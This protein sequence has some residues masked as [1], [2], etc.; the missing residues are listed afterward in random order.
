MSDVRR[1]APPR[2]GGDASR[3]VGSLSFEDAL[4]ELEQIVRGLEGGQHEAR[5]R[6]RLL[7]ARH[8]AAAALRGEAGRG[9]G[10][11]SPAIVARTDGSLSLRPRPAE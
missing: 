1:Q 4:A 3:D 11:A 8:A 5:R 7:R 10:S 6:D 9:R 2:A